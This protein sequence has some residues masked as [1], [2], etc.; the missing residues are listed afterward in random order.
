M[1]MIPSSFDY[2]VP[3]TLD[4]AIA[5]LGEHDGDA[6]ILSG[7][8]SLIPAMNFRCFSGCSGRCCGGG[9]S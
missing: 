1:S 3:S 6:K 2:V 9:I 5:V 8:Q 7:G 4:E